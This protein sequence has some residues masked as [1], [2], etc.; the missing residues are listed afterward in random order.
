MSAADV[1]RRCVVIRDTIEFREG[2]SERL[3]YVRV[4]PAV[5]YVEIVR[6]SV[7]RIGTRDSL[8][9]TD[10]GLGV[11]TR[12]GTLLASDPAWAGNGEGGIAVGLR[13]QCRV[14][15]LLAP[16]FTAPAHPLVL[17]RIADLRS[18]AAETPVVEVL[19]TDAGHCGRRDAG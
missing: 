5:A 17:E 2:Q 18:G 14:S 7:W 12:V 11:G 8:L 1:T 3:M 6:D 4:G 9:R 15:F 13:G 10:D 16:M 19:V